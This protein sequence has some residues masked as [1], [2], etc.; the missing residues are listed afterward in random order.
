MGKIMNGILEKFINEKYKIL[1]LIHDKQISFG[2]FSYCNLSQEE[3]A[4]IVKLSK[5]K[6]N[7]LINELEQDNFIG[8]Y[9]AKKNKYIVLDSGKE[10][11]RKFEN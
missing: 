6:V 3:I 2:D 4:S 1:K 7:K 11:I 10:V 5:V 8:H 9:N